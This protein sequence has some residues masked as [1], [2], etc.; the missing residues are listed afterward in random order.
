MDS[1]ARK[2]DLLSSPTRAGVL[3]MGA[4]AVTAAVFLFRND[5]RAVLLVLGGV[6]AVGLVLL[7]YGAAV[8]WSR[9]RKADPFKHALLGNAAATAGISEP[10]RRA[11]L[12]DLRKK[13]E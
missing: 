5:A 9:H 10:A 8:N 13:F 1:P 4:V 6:A 2:I 3:I 12:E 11:A 7:G